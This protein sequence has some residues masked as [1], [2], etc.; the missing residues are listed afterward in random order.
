M[1]ACH[2]R[3]RP[4][5][6]LH[7]QQQATLQA[8]MHGS[9]VVDVAG[10]VARRAPRPALPRAAGLPCM[11]PQGCSHRPRQSVSRL[12]HVPA[13]PGAG[14]AAGTCFPC[15]A[16]PAGSCDSLRKERRRARVK[17]ADAGGRAHWWTPGAQ[18]SEWR[19]GDM[20]AGR[21]RP[22]HRS[23]SQKQWPQRATVT[24]VAAGP[25]SAAGSWGPHMCRRS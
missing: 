2:Q 23:S 12:G 11:L 17:Q 25:A 14:P 10:R 22:K 20:E 4:R 6:V 13:A 24:A 19:V 15:P 1:V 5:R 9:T 3:G 16:S 8:G 7:S 21:G 18:P